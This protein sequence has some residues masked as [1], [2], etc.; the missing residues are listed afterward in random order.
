MQHLLSPSSLYAAAILDAFR[1]GDLERL[2]HGI[3]Q[4]ATL[5]YEG[6]GDAGELERIELLQGVAGTIQGAGQP[7]TRKRCTDY[8]PILR[9]LANDFEEH[10]VQISHN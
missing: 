5:S 3:A 10:L 2:E 6:F 4:A 9:H 7:G 8:L 1:N